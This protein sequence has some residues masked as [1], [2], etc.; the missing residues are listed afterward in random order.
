MKKLVILFFCF[1][2]FL[3]LI[4]CGVSKKTIDNAEQRIKKLQEKG[5][6][7]SSLS[8]AKVFLYQT[9]SADEDGNIGLA[10]KSADSMRF[11]VAKAEDQY[12]Q[13]MARLQPW[14]KSEREGLIREISA[15]SGL[16]KKYA[17]SVVAVIDSFVTLNWLLQAEAYITQLKD[18][19]P[20]IKFNEERANEIKPRLIGTWTCTNVTKHKHDPSVKAIEKKVFTFNKDGSV[21][22]V[23][24]KNGKSTPYFK[25]DWEF[26]SFGKY[27]CKGDTI[28]LFIDRFKI[29]KH[30][31]W[32]KKKVDGKVKWVKNPNEETYDST[33]TDNSQD[34]YIIFEDL[35][36]DFV[37]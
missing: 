10:R 2:T 25:E 11:Y 20:Q 12:K 6:P 19:L 37:R 26:R 36:T 28:H 7:D 32:D 8:R 34:R 27:D 30:N 22:L 31:F 5:V 29:A 15:F 4:G 14:V 17:D 13:D 21:K 33:I 3:F 18:Y 16:Q 24:K 23:E 9:V 35:R 1:T